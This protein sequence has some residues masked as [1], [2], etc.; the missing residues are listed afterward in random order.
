MSAATATPPSNARAEQPAWVPG[1][2]VLAIRQ[3]VSDHERV[4]TTSDLDPSIARSRG[5]HERVERYQ[6]GR[7]PHLSSIRSTFEGGLP[8]VLY[9]AGLPQNKSGRR[10]RGYVFVPVDLTEYPLSDEGQELVDRIAADEAELRDAR[11]QSARDNGKLGGRPSAAQQDAP[12]EEQHAAGADDE[13]AA[14]D[15]SAPPVAPAA[16]PTAASAASGP[17]PRDTREV[18][19]YLAVAGDGCHPKVIARL[20]ALPL[21]R[22]VDALEDL[23][24]RALAETWSWAPTEAGRAAYRRR[25]A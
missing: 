25:G 24:G 13:P 3:Y 20:T 15:A 1:S 17:L 14:A 4:P 5:E 21:E 11:Q 9:L 6:A 12:E 23:R 10:P 7:Y 8:Q 22:V 2:I 19:A 18:L 16:A